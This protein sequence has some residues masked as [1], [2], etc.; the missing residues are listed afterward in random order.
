MQI[1]CGGFLGFIDDNKGGALLVV[2]KDKSKS[3]Y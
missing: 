3:L 2:I 1:L